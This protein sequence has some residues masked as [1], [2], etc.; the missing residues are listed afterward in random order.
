METIDSGKYKPLGIATVDGE[1]ESITPFLPQK[2]GKWAT[3]NLEGREVPRHDWPKRPRSW[4]TTSPNFGDGARY[5]YSSQIHTVMVTAMQTLHG[6]AFAFDVTSKKRLDGKVL[7]DFMLEPVFPSSVSLESPDLLMAVSLTKEV[8]GTPRV[9][10]IKSGPS[11][12]QDR[13]DFDWEFLPVDHNGRPTLDY[14]KVA[15]TLGILQGS[16]M[17]DTFK[18][19]Y[20]T[21]RGMEPKAIRYGNTGFAR[22]VAFEFD[23]AVVLENYSY[24]N[25]AYV[26]YEDWKELSQRTRLELL[27]DS[28][29]RFE[30]VIHTGNWKGKLKEAIE[31]HRKL[32]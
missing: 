3:W 1:I 21:I 9:F 24:G 16:A 29:A 32:G 17:R 19:R 12:W 10:A 2:P 28:S 5:G 15:D 23:K 4:V 7:L 31:G 20:S 18:E 22:Y 26:M 14:D 25:A 11:G 8:V 27:A 30:R 13:Q 6:K